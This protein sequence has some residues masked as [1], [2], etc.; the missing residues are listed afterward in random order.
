MIIY[1][2][3]SDDIFNL[4]F[5]LRVNREPTLFVVPKNLEID[6]PSSI[7]VDREDI[8]EQW[9]IGCKRSP[10][11]C[12][13]LSN[14]VRGPFLPRWADTTWVEAIASVKRE[15]QPYV[16]SSV[17][18][19][20]NLTI[21]SSEAHPYESVFSGSH[22]LLDVL[23]VC[24]DRLDNGVRTA[25]I[26]M[27]YYHRED[28]LPY[29][30]DYRN[31]C[32]IPGIKWTISPDSPCPENDALGIINRRITDRYI[33]ELPQS[34]P[35][36]SGYYLVD[37]N[38]GLC[39]GLTN[40]LQT[41]AVAIWLS[42]I[43]RRNL[44]VTGFYHTYNVDEKIPL[45]EV[46]DIDSLREYVKKRYNIDIVDLPRDIPWTT[47]EKWRTVFSDRNEDLLTRSSY[48]KMFSTIPDDEYVYI[49]C[50]F[51]YFCMSALGFGPGRGTGFPKT[52]ERLLELLLEIKPS[53]KIRS[54]CIDRNDHISVHYRLE[55]DILF[56]INDEV[57]RSYDNLIEHY[58]DFPI[59]IATGLGKYPN[60]NNELLFNL[61]DRYN[62]IVGKTTGRREIDA[63][64][65]LV[66]MVKGKVF[67][68]SRHS[69]F[70]AL[71]AHIFK[72][73]GKPYLT[74]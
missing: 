19:I 72:R 59:Y 67:I 32:S 73:E 62:I 49:G 69:S 21:S 22:P 52:A 12:I 37:L 40:Q 8:K 28:L 6:I 74:I 2:V 13:L 23:T 3:L 56:A 7:R 61:L 60:V 34:L 16:V 45:E 29:L 70:S 53:N 38:P 11:R 9:R 44:V 26:A 43:K 71:V 50:T 10:G 24:H 68:G 4:R 57:I 27:L 17:E 35:T 48:A 39:S 5:Y 63:F 58:K 54:T 51:D 46:I 55:D 65:D 47:W 66:N 1:A 25:S 64:T 31:R 33:E 30:L 36:A 20:D 15:H 18:E 41:L 14:R 42:A